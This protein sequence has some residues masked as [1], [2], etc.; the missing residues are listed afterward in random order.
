MCPLCGGTLSVSGATPAPEEEA[1]VPPP[2]WEDP[3]V[4]LPRAF[5]DTWVES[6]A[7]PTDLFRRVPWEHAAARPILYFLII[8]ILSAFFTMWWEAMLGSTEVWPLLAELGIARETGGTAAVLRFFLAPFA[9]LLWLLASS[10]LFHLF[11]MLLARDRRS[12]RATIRT[13]CYASGPGVLAV[14]PLV[15]ALVGGLWSLVLVAIG[16]R[17]AHRMTGGASATAVI[18]A[19]LTPMLFL[20]GLFFLLLVAGLMAR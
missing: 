3:A 17:E 8:A 4:P 19:V 1:G 6:L 16:L 5:L 13:A 7:R 18:L 12:F 10:L 20:I 9:A 14:V 15:G 11:V 2:P